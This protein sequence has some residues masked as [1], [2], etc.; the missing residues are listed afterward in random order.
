MSPGLMG[1]LAHVAAA[2]NPLQSSTPTVPGANSSAGFPLLSL[3]VWLPLVGALLILA[4]PSR[5]EEDWGRI[6]NIALSFTFVPFFL[7]LIAIFLTLFVD[8][9]VAYSGGFRFEENYS[10]LGVFGAQYHVGVDGIS[11]PL[12]LLSTLLFFV[13]TAASLKVKTR[14]KE[15]FFLLLILDIG[16]TG[17]FTAMDLLLFFIFWEIEL[18]PMFLLI[19]IWGG[20]RRVYAAWKFLLYTIAASAAL[21]LAILVL[22]FKGGAHTFDMATLSQAHLAPALAGTLFWLFFICFAIKLPVWPL[23]TWLPDAH[24][25]APTPMSVLLAGVLLK[26]G[27]YGMIRICV[28]FFPG[29]VRYYSLAILT[30]AVIGILWG[31]FAALAQD[32]MKRMVAY[33]SVSHMGFV[34]LGI[35]ALTPLALNG[36]VFQ[37]F[38]HGVVTGSLFLLVGLVYDRAHTRSISE[39][40]G[41][42]QRMPYLTTLWVIGALAS[43]GLPG[44]VGFVAEFEIFV[45]SYGAHHVGTLL[46]VFGVVLSAGYLLWMLERVFYGPIKEAWTKLKDP[47]LGELSYMFLMLAMVFF[48]GVFPGKLTQLID[49]AVA[50]LT[51]RL[52]GG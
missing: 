38:A 11:L 31:G 37:L 20:K 16:V 14:V 36:A 24:V 47:G 21:M 44:F 45:G 41:L 27:G 35:S 2:I 33:S 32:D 29:A 17:V 49:Y 10:W 50:P 8:L 52:G 13:A 15:Y 12:V 43:V 9:G 5:T 28:G 19:L 6:R 51:Q 4:L 42:A 23:H 30:L 18:I 25:E 22:Y 48:V 40:G 34:L 39:L 3:I 1:T 46:A 7:A 26:M